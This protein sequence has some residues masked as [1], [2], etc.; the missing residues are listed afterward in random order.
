LFRPPIRAWDNAKLPRRTDEE[1]KKC[2]ALFLAGCP[3][4]LDRA[5]RGADGQLRVRC[6][7]PWFRVVIRQMPL[8]LKLECGRGE[9]LNIRIKPL[10]W[11]V[12]R[13]FRG[14]GLLPGLHAQLS[15][16]LVIDASVDERVPVRGVL[17]YAD[18]LVGRRGQTTMEEP[19]VRGGNRTPQINLTRRTRSGW[20]GQ[21]FRLLKQMVRIRCRQ[22]IPTLP[23]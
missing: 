19:V 1:S 8:F 11:K 17:P 21:S 14:W 20:G 15:Q 6:A 10:G 7:E 2:F 9:R 13:I 3:E 12:W 23:L 5:P 16:G 18:E 4:S 22:P